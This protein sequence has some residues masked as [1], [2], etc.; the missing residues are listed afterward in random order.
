[1]TDGL[2]PSPSLNVIYLLRTAGFDP[3]LL[4]SPLCENEKPCDGTNKVIPSLI[5]TNEF[6]GSQLSNI[7]VESDNCS[8]TPCRVLTPVECGIPHIPPRRVRVM[9]IDEALEGGYDSDGNVGPFLSADVEY[10]NLFFHG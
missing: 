10:E 1:M 4:S 8:S 5:Q 2:S 9:P 3:L 7:T 6:E